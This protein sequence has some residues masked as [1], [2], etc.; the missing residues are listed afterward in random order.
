MRRLVLLL[1]F[2]LTFAFPMSALADTTSDYNAKVAAAQVR[3]SEAQARLTAL[4]GQLS[5]LQSSSAG[6]AQILADAQTAVFLA[7]E[8]VVSAQSSYGAK[9]GVYASALSAVELA[10]DVVNAA[11]ESVVGAANTADSMY[12]L[13][14]AAVTAR[15]IAEA[16][17]VDA[18][19]AYDASSVTTGSTPLPGL[20]VKVFN[21]INTFGNPP[22]RSDSVYQLCKSTTVTNIQA[23]WGGGFVFG[24]N[25]DFVM[26]HYSGYV[27]YAVAKTMYFMAQADDGF[28]MSIN[29][30][31][32]INDW[33]LKGCGANSVG[34][35]TFDANKSYKVDAWFY[36]WGGGACSTLYEMPSDGSSW[37]VTPASAFTQGAVAVTTK[38]AALKAILDQKNALFVSAVAAE[39]Q[40]ASNYLAS[41]NAYDV[42]VSVYDVKVAVLE[43]KQAALLIAETALTDA[44]NVWQDKSDAYSDAQSAYLS[45]KSQFQ[46]LFD[47][48]K[49]K[50]LEVDTAQVALDASKAALIAIPKPTAP[51]KVVK[52]PVIKPAPTVKPT[53]KVTFVPSPKR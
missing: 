49:A 43:Q 26:V 15:G 53:P 29:G 48:L 23:D 19:A 24:C 31:T 12:D 9:Q 41:E 6:N 11:S 25:S 16:N 35:Y 52:K 27:T 3:V 44:E 1:T 5:A 14:D 47:Q 38:D 36:E 4:Q 34:A 51:V 18:Q 39:E 30:Q 28:F 40:A 42:A 20:S 45:R 33:S 7:N 10:V 2:L 17:L 50:S 13:Y 32:V 37:S 22:Q 46:V 8:A 21:G